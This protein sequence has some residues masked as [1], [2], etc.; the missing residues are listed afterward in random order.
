[1][2]QKSLKTFVCRL[3]LHIIA[4]LLMTLSLFL[5]SFSVH[6]YYDD[7]FKQLG[8][9]KTAADQKITKSLL[10]GYPDVYGIHNAKQIAIGNRSAVVKDL[11]DYTKKYTA[12]ESFKKE[13]ADLKQSNK[14]VEYTIESPEEMRKN[15]IDQF[16][17]SIVEME[18]AVKKAD[19]ATKQIFENIVADS[20]KQLKDAEDPNNKLIKNYSNNYSQLLKSYQDSYDLQLV[21]WESKY[22]TN[23][24]LFVKQR[25]IRFLDE[26][27]DI[28]FNAELTNRNGKKIFVNPAYEHRG[29]NWKMAFRAGK[30]V[31]EP[32]R[33]FVKQWADEIK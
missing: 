31:V 30:E 23:E 25:L 12:T 26:T 22:P 24:M 2:K 27:K 32:A 13:Y 20:K 17:K 33:A 29:K 6:K 11:L 9:E 19:G 10:G 5:F 21:E 16:R 7:L 8:I 28:D 4:F 3:R 1:M 14:P 15:M 18:A